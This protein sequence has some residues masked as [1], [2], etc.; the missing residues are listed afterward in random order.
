MNG[1]LHP[2]LGCTLSYLHVRCHSHPVEDRSRR[3]KSFRGVVAVGLRG[4]AK[5]GRGTDVGERPDHTLQATALVHE[6]YLRLVDTDQVAGWNSRGHF[7]SA[8]AEAM[9]RILVDSARA[10]QAQKRG[11]DCERVDLD[12]E[13]VETI[14]WDQSSLLDLNDAIER[15]S[16]ADPEAAELIKLR[17]FA[18]LSVTESGKILRMS[19]RTAYDNWDFA[20]AW[21]IAQIS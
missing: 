7:F 11:G 10:N 18:G 9:R 3:P 6:A 14:C 19:K 16:E 4:V 1:W 2:R 5:A 13:I 8:A 12:P 15:L 17:L 21:F 20:R